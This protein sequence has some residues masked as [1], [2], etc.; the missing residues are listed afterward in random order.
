MET[1]TTTELK[2]Y[3]FLGLGFN[4]AEGVTEENET[5][6]GISLVAFRNNLLSIAIADGDWV[7]KHGQPYRFKLVNGTLFVGK[8]AVGI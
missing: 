1:V 8:I 5:I 3:R 7:D 4:Y 6:K 2:K